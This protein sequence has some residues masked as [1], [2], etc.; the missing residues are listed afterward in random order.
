MIVNLKPALKLVHLAQAASLY[1]YECCAPNNGF[2]SSSVHSGASSP[3]DHFGDALVSGSR[4]VVLIAID[5]QQ[6][7]GILFNSARIGDAC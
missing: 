7:I 1:S 3:L 6:Q 2:A 5:R 4:F